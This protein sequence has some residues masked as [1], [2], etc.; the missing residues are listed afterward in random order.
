MDMDYF[1]LR[2]ETNTT[3]IAQKIALI[4]GASSGIGRAFAYESAKE[5]YS[6]VL[7]ARREAKLREIKESI[8]QQYGVSVEYCVADLGYL[9]DAK[10][11][12]SYY[13]RVDLLINA[14][15]SGVMG[16]TVD[17][18]LEQEQKM[19]DLNIKSLQ[20]LTSVY[21]RKMAEQNAGSII[22]VASTS[23]FTAFPNFA[24]Y[25]ATKAFVLS[26]TEAV[27]KEL[28]AMNV[29]VM[30]LCPGAVDTDF[31]DVEKKRILQGRVGNLPLMM[32]PQRIAKEALTAL[33]YKKRVCIPGFRHRLFTLILK[34]MP[35][36]IL[37]N[38]LC[39][40]MKL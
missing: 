22:N 14:A 32:E 24:V 38:L 37:L 31:F 28:E 17:L 29:H 18:S 19:I 25:A 20:Y 15:G 35:R 40:Y 5:G 8:E 30:A 39:R 21:G 6:L 4:T 27:S 12:F 3:N 2:A 1:L 34:F 33:K 13:K 26:Y 11:I 36:E 7:V 23:A 9:E 10:K 16:A